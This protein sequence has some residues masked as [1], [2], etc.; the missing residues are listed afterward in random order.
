MNYI[1]LDLE[2]NQPVS[3]ETKV[4]KTIGDRLMFELIQIGAVKL[5]EKQN[6]VDAISLPIKPT[7]YQIIHPRIRRL[8]QLN[9]QS[10]AFSPH[11][12]EAI[13]LFAKWCGNEYMLITWGIDDASVLQQNIDFFK[14]GGK[15]APICDL[16]HYFS[17]VLTLGK[18][19]KGLKYAMEL[20]DINQQE[21]LSFHNA[22]ND[23]YYTAQVFQKLP[24]PKKIAQYQV[25]PKKL[26]KSRKKAFRQIL[27]LPSMQNAKVL[28]Q[29]KLEKPLCPYCEKETRLSGKYLP[30]GKDRYGGLALCKKHGELL[31][32][33]EIK[34]QEQ[35]DQVLLKLTRA[36]E[37]NKT[38][39]YAKM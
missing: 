25:K 26:G 37:K 22:L 23:A 9:K 32:E 4:Y 30:T 15:L 7:H 19:R 38:S 14:W 5:D 11:F 31:V 39:Y 3:F 13:E 21:Q 28:K 6:I 2:W 29:A 17:D 27:T 8:T 12:P 10:L 1:V 24:H 36:T 33:V 34:H 35:K 20:F 18:E 16:Q